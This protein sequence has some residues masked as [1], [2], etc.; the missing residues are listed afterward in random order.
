MDDQTS[1]KLDDDKL[2]DDDI[3]CHSLTTMNMDEKQCSEEVT[4]KDSDDDHHPVNSKVCDSQIVVICEDV[5]EIKDLNTEHYSEA[6]VET[7]NMS[8]LIT[9]LQHFREIFNYNDFF[10][11][12]ILSLAPTA[13]EVSM[14]YFVGF[15]LE[16]RGEAET[17]GL[18]YMIICLP[19]CWIACQRIAKIL[20][21]ISIL[22]VVAVFWISFYVYFLNPT[23]FKYPA[24]VSSLF[25]LG[26]KI[27]SVFIHNSRIK[28]LSMSLSEAEWRTESIGQ[29]LLFLYVWILGGQIYL[30][31]MVSSIMLIGKVNLPFSFVYL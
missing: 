24:I 6:L 27:T 17:A 12:L 18:C 1:V 29:Y 7:T 8:K 26:V 5:E 16:D 15:S 19:V 30:T 28:L 14:D 11:N 10:S 3:E 4:S 13:W 21:N 23:I 20:G 25:T 9:Y 22:I 31:G 2:E